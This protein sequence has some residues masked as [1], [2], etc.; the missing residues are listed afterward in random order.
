MKHDKVGLA[1]LWNRFDDDLMMIELAL[2][3][4]ALDSTARAVT[5]NHPCAFQ[6]WPKK[7]RAE[8]SL[9]PAPIKRCLD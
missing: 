5:I 9:S 4:S 1:S 2:N 3:A 6:K 8:L 7:Y